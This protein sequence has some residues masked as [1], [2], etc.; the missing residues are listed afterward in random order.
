[1][2][3]KIPKDLPFVLVRWRDPWSDAVTSVTLKDV[4]ETHKP[5]LIV[6]AGWLLL[7]DEEGV[8]LACEY[9]ADGSFRG[10]SFIIASLIS[11]IE[12]VSLVPPRHRKP[13]TPKGLSVPTS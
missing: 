5:E 3:L 12:C 1:M 8:S 11:S 9:C 13:R 7:Q 4:H 10:R 6:T 2:D